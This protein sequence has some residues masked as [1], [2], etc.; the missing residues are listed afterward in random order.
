MN[1]AHYSPE[2]D[3]IILKAV[4]DSPTNILAGLKKAAE[5]L[6]Y[7]SFYSVRNRY[8]AYLQK[9]EKNHLFFTVS[10]KKKAKNY[11]VTR[12]GRKPT[13]YNPEKTGMSK[14]KRILAILFE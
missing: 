6:P 4:K 11:K 9:D 12:R 1:E 14:W 3:R 7:R 10:S 8:Y 5:L 2:E 13:K